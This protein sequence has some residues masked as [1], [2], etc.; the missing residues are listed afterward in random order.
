MSFKITITETRPV[1]KLVGKNW[2]VIGTNEV[3]RD[4][5]Y[6]QSDADQPKTRIEDVR[7]YTPEIEKTVEETRTVLEQNIDTL[8]L[9]NV[10]KAI[11][12]I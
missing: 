1:K 4:R 10:I 5:Q 8:N 2:D 11:N 3:P 9:V 6:Y 12:G 7:G